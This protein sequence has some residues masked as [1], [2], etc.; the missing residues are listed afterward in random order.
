MSSLGEKNHQVEMMNIIYGNASRVCIW[1]GDATESSRM[2]LRFIKKEVSHLRSF[3][4]LC[5]SQ[6]ASKKW[7]ALLD[8]MQRP[9][10][11]RRWVVQELALAK[12]PIIYCGRDRISWKKFAVAV[13]LFVE[14]ETATHRLSEVMKK[15]RQYQY[16]PSVFDYVSALGASLLVDATERLFRDYKKS[17]V[18]QPMP[19]P[20][21]QIESITDSDS[22]ASLYTSDSEDD[23]TSAPL[24]SSHAEDVSGSSRHRIQPLL[25]LEYLV[26]SLTIF[27]TTVPHDTIYALLA[28]AKDTTPRAV[29]VH[30]AVTSRSAQ[31][32]LEVYTQRKSYNVD[33]KLPYV[34][35]CKDFI[36]FSI[37]R[38]LHGNASRALDVICRPWAIEERKLQKIRDTK[39]KE[40]EKEQRRKKR[41]KDLEAR[42]KG[43]ESRKALS[44][45][46][47]FP[48]PPEGAPVQNVSTIAESGDMALPSWVPQ[49]SNA[50][51]AMAQR[52]GLTGPKMSRINAD[53]LVGLPSSYSA[54]ETKGVDIKALRFRKRLKP[55]HFDEGRFSMYVRGFKLDVI[56]DVTQ[57][58]RNG[59]IPAEWLDLAEWEDGKGL[60]PDM[61]WRTLV[62]NRGK[63]GKNPP[64]YYS[65][66]CQE[67]FRKGGLESGAIDTTA[68]IEYERN[69]VV[70]QFCRRVQAVTWN[71]ALVRTDLGTLGLV[72]K[73]VQKGDL[74]CILYGCSVPVVLRECPKKTEEVFEEEMEQ[75][76]VDVKNTVVQKLRQ[77]I[78][79]KRR[80]EVW[81]DKEMAKLCRAWLRTTDYIRKLGIDSTKISAKNKQD[82]ESILLHTLKQ[83][84]SD[85][86]S[87]LCEERKKAWPAFK[88]HIDEEVN[89]RKE[90]PRRKVNRPGKKETDENLRRQTSRKRRQSLG[91]ATMLG[92]ITEAPTTTE[93]TAPTASKDGPAP[94]KKK[95]PLVDWWEFE[96]A[97]VAGRRW[98]QMARKAKADRIAFALRKSEE[99]WK[100]VQRGEYK[101]VRELVERENR[102]KLE[103]QADEHRYCVMS[104]H[105]T[106]NG[107]VAGGHEIANKGP[108]RNDSPRRGN[109]EHRNGYGD[110]DSQNHG[111][112][113]EPYSTEEYERTE[114]ETDPYDGD[115]KTKEEPHRNGE[116]PQ[117]SSSL[118]HSIPITGH[119]PP[120]MPETIRPSWRRPTNRTRLTKSQAV[121]YKSKVM[122]N[123]RER[124][125]EE[126]YFSYTLLGECYIH[127][128]MDGEAMQ[129]QNE[130]AEGVIPSMVFEIR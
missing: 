122:E 98:L 101:G 43:R 50:P 38:S 48:D 59:H 25:S 5:D 70:A 29:S 105:G 66:A 22:E 82:A 79:R 1:L 12:N 15:D 86:K 115:H 129:H 44:N 36:Q 93:A 92:R 96:L 81:K 10:F 4:T 97:L 121:D 40:K 80:H 3:D 113:D 41:E 51:Y 74:V 18:A 54:A 6:D 119:A 28:I 72:G 64:V 35:V 94:I 47:E 7:V 71:R 45:H 99:E 73:D 62:A 89:E 9:W 114:R 55:G 77:Y 14:V 2:A 31:A 123:L 63:D 127:G 60:P 95:K 61:F 107:G 124:L 30:A 58:S 75:E 26:S 76:L 49:L 112:N 69:S 11:S 65:R 13:E 33:Y 52:P 27:D 85:F 120:V 126:G 83:F 37:D 91:A 111:D 102:K 104:E 21:A 100:E 84:T 128:M 42:R 19:D 20:Q 68:L 106:H 109:E 108:G 34:D 78:L 117:T 118:P 67:S 116:T 110:E 103:R 90:Y 56:K 87:W 32:G 8:L 24:H 88:T 23:Y 57:V 125:G 17:E 39:E 16:I 130:G 46:A 53:P